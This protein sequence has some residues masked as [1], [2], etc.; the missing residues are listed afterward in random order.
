MRSQL[1]DL[2]CLVTNVCSYPAKRERDVPEEQWKIGERILLKLINHCLPKAIL[3]QGKPAVNFGK[4]HFDSDLDRYM[5]PAEQ[6]SV[7]DGRLLLAYHHFTGM[8]LQSGTEFDF[9]YASEVFAKKIRDHVA[10]A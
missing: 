1:G 4:K 2:N 8:G 9:E 3:F 7:V 6:G 5:P 10:N